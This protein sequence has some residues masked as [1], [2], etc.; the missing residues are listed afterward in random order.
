[1]LVDPALDP[2]LEPQTLARDLMASRA[3]S[4]RVTAGLGGARLLGPKLAIVNPPLWEIGHVAWFQERWCLRT[5]F[6][7]ELARFAARRGGCAVRLL[8][9]AARHALGAAAARS[10][11]DPRLR[12]KRARGGARAP[13]ARAGERAAALLRAPGDPAR[14]HARRGVP[15]HAPHAGLRGSVAG[16]A[17]VSGRAR[18]RTRAMPSAPAA[19]SSSARA[20]AAAS[21]ST[22]RSG[23]TRC[24]WRRFASRARR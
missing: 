23:R 16:G 12:G 3:R 19:R 7:G 17:L 14:G 6:A 8:R 4:S 9:R 13:R 5:G 2:Q 22:T 24:A 10:R 11:G 20:R 1:M 15:L 21:C 18:A